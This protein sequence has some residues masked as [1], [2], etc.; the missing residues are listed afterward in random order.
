MLIA[1]NSFLRHTSTAPSPSTHARHFHHAFYHRPQPRG[2]RQPLRRPGHQPVRLPVPHR[3]QQRL[4]N[5][6]RYTH[7]PSMT[8]MYNLTC[9]SR[10]V[11]GPARLMPTHLPATAGRDVHDDGRKR[12]RHRHPHVQLRVRRQ[13]GSQH[14]AVLADAALLHLPPVGHPVRRQLRPG[15]EYLRRQVPVRPVTHVYLFTV[16][17][18]I[19]ADHPCGAQQ[20]YRGNTSIPSASTARATPSGTSAIV[21]FNDPLATGSSAPGKGAAVATF[22]PSTGLSVAALCGSVLLGFAVFL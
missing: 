18:D 2:P 22:V 5:R 6:P 17:N 20:P 1:H 7:I 4:H 12:L 19:S 16:A 11:P 13:Q 15:L 3:P 9:H 10:M 14:H 8:A 21:G